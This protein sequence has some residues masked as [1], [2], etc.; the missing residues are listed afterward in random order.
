M[1]I[2]F[3]TLAARVKSTTART[4]VGKNNDIPL[5][6]DWMFLLVSTFTLAL[7]LFGFGFYLFYHAAYGD[8]SSG[9][10]E[11]GAFGILSRAR[12]TSVLEAYSEREVLFTDLKRNP[13]DVTNP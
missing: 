7:F 3:K 10:S 4:P 2:N 6:R 1:A 12:L 13:P 8:L 11:S 9:D 5:L